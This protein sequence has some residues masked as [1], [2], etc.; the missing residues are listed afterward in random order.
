MGKSLLRSLVVLVALALVAAACSKPKSNNANG[1]ALSA[2]QDVS[3]IVTPSTEAPTTTEPPAVAAA[4]A[5][6]KAK[7]VAGSTQSS[8]NPALDD[9]QAQRSRRQDQAPVHGA[10]RSR[11]TRV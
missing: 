8:R 2:N 11:T 1:K 7:V 10:A 3:D 6:A 5:A 4:A 9:A